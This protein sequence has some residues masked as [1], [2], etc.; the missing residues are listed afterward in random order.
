[1]LCPPDE[2][3]G[4][5]LLDEIMLSGNF[6]QFDGR[7]RRNPNDRRLKKFA[8]K[9]NRQLRFLSAFPSEV[10][11]FPF[12]RLW[13][14]LWRIGKGYDRIPWPRFSA[15]RDK[16]LPMAPPRGGAVHGEPAAD[17]RKQEER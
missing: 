2:V 9:S 5:F 14:F 4:V 11:A 3:W 15:D 7:L 12:F 6:G 16:A 17:D 8:K 10:L 1:M 13:Q